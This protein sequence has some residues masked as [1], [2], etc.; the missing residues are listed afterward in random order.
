MEEKEVRTLLEAKGYGL[1]QS[2]SGSY[3]VTKGGSV[4]YPVVSQFELNEGTS[5]ERLIADLPDLIPLG[6]T[7]EK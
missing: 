1:L 5:L 4:V 7:G 3:S 6:D 2:T